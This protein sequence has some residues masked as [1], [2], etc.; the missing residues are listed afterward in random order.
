MNYI[1]FSSTNVRLTQHRSLNMQSVSSLHCRNTFAMFQET[2]YFWFISGFWILFFW[3][4][5]LSLGQY[6]II[7]IVKLYSKFLYLVL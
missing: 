6:Y 1:D 7:L 5:C 3:F 4:I 2:T